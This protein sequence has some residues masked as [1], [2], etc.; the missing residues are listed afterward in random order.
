MYSKFW[1]IT[2]CRAKKN[3][4]INSWFCKTNSIRLRKYIIECT[5]TPWTKNT[6]RAVGGGGKSWMNE[7]NGD[8]R[9]TKNPLNHSVRRWIQRHLNNNLSYWNSASHKSW[10]YFI[11]FRPLNVHNLPGAGNCYK[12]T[13]FN[14]KSSLTAGRIPTAVPANCLSPPHPSVLHLRLDLPLFRPFG[15][16]ATDVLFTFLLVHKP[17]RFS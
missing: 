7:R 8:Q 11:L 10:N 14:W 9:T 3:Y 5:I 15:G 12:G 4:W 16:M 6:A 13:H 1:H 17:T 2:N